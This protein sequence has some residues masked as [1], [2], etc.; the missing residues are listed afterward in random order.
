MEFAVRD[1]CAA[2]EPLRGL[3]PAERL[4]VPR[5]SRRDYRRD[6]R[7]DSTAVHHAVNAAPAQPP[8]LVGIAGTGVARYTN[9]I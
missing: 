8:P 2:F 4:A 9:P 7:R 6:Y 5:R 3:A 1:R